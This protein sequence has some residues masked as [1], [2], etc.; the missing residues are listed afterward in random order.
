M[1]CTDFVAGKSVDFAKSEKHASEHL[2]ELDDFRCAVDVSRCRGS[3]IRPMPARVAEN[4]EYRAVDYGKRSADEITDEPRTIDISRRGEFAEE[5]ELTKQMIWERKLLD[6]SLRNSLLN[7]RPGASSIQFMTAD[8]GRLEDE[9]ARGEDFKIMASPSELHLTL[10][11]SKIYEI[12]NA[13]DMVTSIAEAEFKSRRLRTFINETELEKIQENSPFLSL[14]LLD[15]MMPKL[16]GIAVLKRIR[17]SGSLMPVLMLTAK[18]EIDDKVEG[19]DSGANDYL[20]KPFNSKELLARIRAMTRV[21]TVQADSTWKFGNITLDRTTCDMTGPKGSVRLS[22]KEY[23]M[24]ELLMNNPRVLISTERFMD[25]IWGIDSDADISV[26]WTF[27]SYLRKKLVSIGA[28]ISIKATRGQ[29]YSL[30]EN[31]E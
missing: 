6:L 5:K 19:L 11:D 31:A 22:G 2:D 18:S 12:E 29:G 28:D 27:L 20:T 30:E 1:E 13:K 26:V 9:I 23:Q 4:G 17:A 25:K 21:S 15:L 14:I 3:G 7:F 16:D 10:S 24:M 8:L